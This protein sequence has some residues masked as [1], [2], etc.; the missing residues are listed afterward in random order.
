MVSPSEFQWSPVA[1][2]VTNYKGV[3]GTSNMGGGWPDSPSGL[4]DN[5]NTKLATGLFFRNSYQVKIRI[6][7]IL[8]G[9]SNTLAVGEDVPEVNRHGAAFYSN[10][11][12]ASSHAPLNYF[13]KPPDPD[14]WPR[15]ISFRSR[16]SGG[17]NFA[18]ADGS[19]RFISQDID[20]FLYQKLCTRS[21]GEAVSIPN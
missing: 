8:D 21:G 20:R 4:T 12:Y 17:V 13:P 3:I 6:N 11:D 5:H 16:H 19:V 18:A 7:Q 9:A 14:N 15:V 2:A 1:V 10:G